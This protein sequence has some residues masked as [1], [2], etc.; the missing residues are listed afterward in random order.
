MKQ[1]SRM[2]FSQSCEN[3]EMLD[4]FT[5]F[6][7]MGSLIIEMLVKRGRVKRMV[8]FEH[9]EELAE[10]FTSIRSSEDL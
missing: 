5:A 2:S 7:A 9:I 10:T 1:S 8:K 3:P 4:F 6:G